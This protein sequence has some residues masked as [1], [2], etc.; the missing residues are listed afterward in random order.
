MSTCAGQPREGLLSGAQTQHPPL[1]VPEE[2]RLWWVQCTARV[3]P[4][5]GASRCLAGTRTSALLTSHAGR[6]QPGSCSHLALC[7][8]AG[9]R[10]ELQTPPQTQSP[11]QTWSITFQAL[12]PGSQAG[13]SVLSPLPLK[14]EA[15]GALSKPRPGPVHQLQKRTWHQA[16]SRATALHPLSSL[17]STTPSMQFQTYV[18][19]SSGDVC[20]VRAT[21]WPWWPQLATPCSTIQPRKT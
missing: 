3:E 19:L 7:S 4:M 5:R 13:L 8:T 1:L 21:G 9:Q 2:Q 18:I 12:M 17:G 14:V 20:S 10:T 11:S 16:G 6:T 15:L